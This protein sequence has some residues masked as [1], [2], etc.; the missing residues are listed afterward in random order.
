MGKDHVEEI[1]TEKDK[2]WKETNDKAFGIT[3]ATIKSFSVEKGQ[4]ECG[5][6]TGITFQDTI[7]YQVKAPIPFNYCPWCGKELKE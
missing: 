2:D 4:A 5:H 3:S 7:V 6:A 1:M